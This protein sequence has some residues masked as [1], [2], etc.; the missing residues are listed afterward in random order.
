MAIK[1]DDTELLTVDSRVFYVS[2]EDDQIFQ[3]YI[4]SVKVSEGLDENGQIQTS[5]KY[6]MRYFNNDS[7][8]VGIPERTFTTVHD[9]V[10]CLMQIGYDNSFDNLDGQACKDYELMLERSRDLRSDRTLVAKS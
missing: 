1:L 3:C 4:L 8:F 9:A 6:K 7:D 2:E 10:L 5:V